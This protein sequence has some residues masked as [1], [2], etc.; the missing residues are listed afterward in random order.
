MS[1]N[2]SAEQ[3]SIASFADSAEWNLERIN[4]YD[5]I[6]LKLDKT[7]GIYT[8][9]AI[10]WDADA[11]DWTDYEIDYNEIKAYIPRPLIG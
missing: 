6:N 10:E 9:F 5:E 2:I 8:A 11:D 7:T 4:G 3:L 1:I